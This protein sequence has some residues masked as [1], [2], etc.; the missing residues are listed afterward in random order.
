VS[1][2]IEHG[3]AL[4]NNGQK[5]RRTALAGGRLLLD[6][7][8]KNAYTGTYGRQCSLSTPSMNFTSR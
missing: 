4:L 7:G 6:R 2:Q 1:G 5:K 3:I 8:V